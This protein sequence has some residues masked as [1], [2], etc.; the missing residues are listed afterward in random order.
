MFWW[1]NSFG[2]EKSL[3]NRTSSSFFPKEEETASPLS[4]A[5]LLTGQICYPFMDP[6]FTLSFQSIYMPVGEIT[7]DAGHAVKDSD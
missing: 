6:R 2:I 7:L 4:E 5:F 3:G 1:N